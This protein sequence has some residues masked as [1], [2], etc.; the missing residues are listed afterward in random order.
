MLFQIIYFEINGQK[1]C[2]DGKKRDFKGFH[3]LH[4]MITLRVEGNSTIKF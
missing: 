2:F 1:I 3:G 4:C